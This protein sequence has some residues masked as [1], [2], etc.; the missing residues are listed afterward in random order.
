M[1]TKENKIINFFD[2]IHNLKI[3]YAVWKNTN[4]ID[5]FYLGEENLDIYIDNNNYFNFKKILDK[6]QW[7]KVINNIR[8]Y[9]FIDHYFLFTKNKIYHLHIYNKLIT[10]DSI[11]KEYDFSELININN[12]FFSEN[13]NLWILDYNVQYLLFKVRFIIKNSNILGKFIFKKQKNYYYNEIIFLNNFTNKG[14]KHYIEI[15]KK[16]FLGLEIDNG[17]KNIK[18]KDAKLIIN[19]LKR[20]KIR[21]LFEI[22]LIYSSFFFKYLQKSFFKR[23]NFKLKEGISLFISGCDSSGKSSLVNEVFNIYEDKIDTKTFTIAKPYPKFIINLANYK[24]IYIK[25]E[26]NKKRNARKNNYKKINFLIIIKNLNLALL[27]YITSKKIDKYKRNKYL[28]ICDRYVSN[29]VNHI[30]G[31][32]IMNKK[33]TLLN[34]FIMNIESFF[35]SNIKPL[36]FEIRLKTDLEIAIFRNNR[37]KKG[38]LKDKN[39]IINRYN[40]FQKSTFKSLKKYEYENN[41]KL[42]KSIEDILIIINKTIL[43]KTNDYN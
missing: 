32:R 16:Y 13:Y 38:E 25:K 41:N 33:N 18:K 12:C 34:N 37:R 30:N 42:Q 27:R 29:Y 43:K 21:N 6:H 22:Y 9:K 20:F 8:N 36:D 4:L 26:S 17:L 24:K 19:N 5:K 1:T 35:Y 10:G 40:L 2:E 3:N 28:I 11:L 39:E 14:D 31:P 15:N 23:K 7:I